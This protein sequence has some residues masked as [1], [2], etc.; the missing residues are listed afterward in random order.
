MS[1]TNTEQALNTGCE[2]AGLR[3]Q[4]VNKE[5]LSDWHPADIVAQVKKKGSSLAALSRHSGL[6]GSTLSNVLH[7]RWPK[8]ER[9]VAEFIGVSPEVIWPTRYRRDYVDP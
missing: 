5:G 8:G 6:A 3:I 2:S 7:R 4:P 1:D 9:I